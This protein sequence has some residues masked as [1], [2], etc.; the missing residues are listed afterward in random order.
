MYEYCTGIVLVVYEKVCVFLES[1][2]TRLAV[3]VS[4][5]VEGLRP[6]G[7][8]AW[9]DDAGAERIGGGQI[10]FQS[11]PDSRREESRAQ[12]LVPVYKYC[13]SLAIYLI[14]IIE[15]N[16]ESHSLQFA[17]CTTRRYGNTV[18]FIFVLLHS[19]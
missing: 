15:I 10:Q 4:G 7:A 1:M 17:N 16:F 8:P 3:Q 12:T 5:R 9:R 18:T 19:S 13:I 6:S 14:N 11:S 2:L